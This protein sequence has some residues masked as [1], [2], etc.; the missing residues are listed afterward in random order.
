MRSKAKMEQIRGREPLTAQHRGLC[1][2]PWACTTGN[3]CNEVN[4]KKTVMEENKGSG[5]TSAVEGRGFIVDCHW[6]WI[7]C[8]SSCFICYDI[9]RFR[10]PV[11]QVVSLMNI[12]LTTP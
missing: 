3:K 8:S 9:V 7:L 1:P 5:I 2:E 12:F 6:T 4:K 10:S 11:E